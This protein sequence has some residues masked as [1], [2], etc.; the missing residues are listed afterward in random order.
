MIKMYKVEQ[1]GTG[2][3]YVKAV[4]V[5]EDEAWALYDTNRLRGWIKAAARY[6]GLYGVEHG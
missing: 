1:A 2:H 6:V 4:E 3:V 5:T